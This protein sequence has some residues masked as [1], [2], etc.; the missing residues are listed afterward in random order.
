MFD[1]IKSAY[2]MASSDIGAEIVIPSGELME[3]LPEMG[4]EKVHRDTFH[5]SLGVGRY[6]IGLLWYAVL[7]GKD[8]ENIPF[9]DLDEPA[10][11]E[12]FKIAKMAVMGILKK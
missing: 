7:T 4:I 10:S 1:N 6:A 9:C 11:D 2:A 5:A 8:V 3:K 12:D